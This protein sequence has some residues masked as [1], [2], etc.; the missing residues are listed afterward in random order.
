MIHW[1][2]LSGDLST[3]YQRNKFQTKSKMQHN[4]LYAIINQ[5]HESEKK[6]LS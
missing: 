2:T 1:K 6:D 3:N 5:M 4:L